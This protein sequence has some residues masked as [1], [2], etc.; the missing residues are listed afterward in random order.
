[1]AQ[2]ILHAMK[3]RIP[4]DCFIIATDG[5]TWAGNVHPA[6]AL[7][8]YREQMGIPAKAVQLAFCSNRVSIMDPADAGTLDIPGF[9]S[10]LPAILHDFMT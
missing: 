3:E 4:V 9:D 5:E 10:A 1:M 6:K 8:D 2:P 7:R